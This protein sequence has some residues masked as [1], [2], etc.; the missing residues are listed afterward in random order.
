VLSVDSQ[1]PDLPLPRS[2]IIFRS[3]VKNRRY[4]LSTLGGGGTYHKRSSYKK[5]SKNPLQEEEQER[6]R[7]ASI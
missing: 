6:E 4:Q 2:S 1:N 5:E 3:S 7:E